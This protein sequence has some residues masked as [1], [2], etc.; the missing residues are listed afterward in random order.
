MDTGTFLK[1]LTSWQFLLVCALVVLLLPL[2]VFL[3]SRKS[4]SGPLRMPAPAKK[5]PARRVRAAAKPAEAEE[6]EAEEE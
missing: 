1:L 3:G 2:V 5:A 6:E 4:R